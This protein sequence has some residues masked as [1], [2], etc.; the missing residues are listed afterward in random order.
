MARIHYGINEGLTNSQL[1]TLHDRSMK[2]LNTVGLDVP[3][4]TSSLF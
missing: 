2:I 3:G 4:R 1:E